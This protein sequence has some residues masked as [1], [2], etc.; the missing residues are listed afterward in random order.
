MIKSL[1]ELEKEHIIRALQHFSGNKTATANALGITLKTL[2]N[3]LHI[4]NIFEENKGRI[5]RAPN[6]RWP[7]CDLPK[8]GL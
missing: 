3:K 6:R 7:Q 8:E 4:H 2:Y 1:F 5:G